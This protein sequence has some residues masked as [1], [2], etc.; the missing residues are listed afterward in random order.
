MDNTIVIKRKKKMVTTVCQN[1]GLKMIIQTP[2]VG[3]V[4]CGK[5]MEPTSWILEEESNE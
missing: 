4:L 2:Y 3:D 1:C 5:C